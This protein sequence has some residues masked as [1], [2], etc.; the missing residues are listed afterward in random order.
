MATSTREVEPTAPPQSFS[1]VPAQ[2]HSVISLEYDESGLVWADMWDNEVLSWVIDQSGA[3]QPQPVILGGMQAAVRATD[4]VASPQWV[5]VGDGNGN[6]IIPNLWRGDLNGLFTYLAT[7]NGATRK[8]RGNFMRPRIDNQ[9]RLWSNQ[10]PGL[11]W[12]GNA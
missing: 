8:L 4:P 3:V 9:W 5:A 7:N 10:N 1:T 11:V 6:V 2:G 12:D